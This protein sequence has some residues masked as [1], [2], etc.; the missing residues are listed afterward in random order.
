MHTEDEAKERWCPFARLIPIGSNPDGTAKATDL[1][2]GNRMA[3]VDYEG[4]DMK[5]NAFTQCIAS[6][7][8][9]WQWDGPEYDSQGSKYSHRRGYCGLAGKP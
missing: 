4:G 3:Q 5:E 9:A 1:P 6:Q 8:M 2:A 7:C